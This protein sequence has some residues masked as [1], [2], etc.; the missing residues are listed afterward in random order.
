MPIITDFHHPTSF[1][2]QSDHHHSH[3]H[4]T[5]FPGRG[6]RGAPAREDTSNDPCIANVKKVLASEKKIIEVKKKLLDA[7][8]GALG[9]SGKRDEIKCQ[10]KAAKSELT[11]AKNDQQAS[12]KNSGSPEVPP[13]GN[14]SIDV[15]ILFLRRNRITQFL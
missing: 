11:K 9:T 7:E 12:A 3:H 5:A 4:A 1:A 15:N 6:G 10:L 14:S 2:T 13:V 8:K